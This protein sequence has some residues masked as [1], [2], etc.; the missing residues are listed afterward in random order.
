MEDIN[1][2]GS[3]L[4]HKKLKTVAVIIAHPYD[5]T[6]WAGGTILSHPSWKWF[7]VCLCRGNDT[8]V[9]PRFYNALK[10]LKSE[11]IMGNLTDG[12]DYKLQ[13]EKL[14]ERSILELLPPKHF[15]L[16]ITYNPSGV[17]N[18][19]FMH[20]QVSNA[21]I[22]LWDAGEIFTSE[23]WTFA[24]SH[25]NMGSYPKS[26]ETASIF[27]KLMKRI[28]LRKFRIITEIYGF[29]EN[30]WEAGG[31]TVEES[32]WQYTNSQDAIKRINQLGEFKTE[33]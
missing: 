31:T 15:D 28:W 29:E 22:K 7:I 8:E 27:R 12:L 1:F 9:A 13:D 32:F 16:I 20:E 3:K 17:N 2:A 21:V 10:S 14:I 33:V 18:R 6:I 25:G 11:G 19:Y 5:E 24:Y 30:S 4:E 26:I 23:L